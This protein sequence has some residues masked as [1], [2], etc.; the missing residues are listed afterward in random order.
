MVTRCVQNVQLVNV[1]LDT[2][3][4]PVK[5]LDSRRVLVIKPLVEKSRNYGCLPN[6]CGAQNHHPVA[7][8]GRDV[9]LVFGR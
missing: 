5:V 2:V 1:S 6:F 4:F 9:E 3:E 8:L 7:I